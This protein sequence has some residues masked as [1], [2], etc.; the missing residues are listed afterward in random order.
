MGLICKDTFICLDC[1]TTGLDPTKDHIVE[2]ALSKFNFSATLESY[3]TLIDPECEIS[4]HSIAIHH[5]TQNMVKGYPKIKEILPLIIKLIGRTII[6]GHGIQ[7]DLN[8]LAEAAKKHH[9]PFDLKGYTLIDTLRMARL[10][11]ES[12]AN[13][14]EKLREHFNIEPEGAH[15]AMSDVIV[16][17]SVFKYLSKSFKTT[18]QLLER[19]KKPILLKTMPLGK[20]KGRPFKEIPLEY[21]RW[22]SH[23]DFDMDLLFSVHNE[24]QKRKKGNRFL[25]A[26]NPFSQL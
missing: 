3:E 25:D 12:P 7:L 1:E 23:A 14:L 5:I 21:L 11:G 19:L 8:F 10:Y 17:I 13:S 2:V 4:E 6:V 22:A 24:L 9:I 18:E 20:Y 15:R 26:S 16:N